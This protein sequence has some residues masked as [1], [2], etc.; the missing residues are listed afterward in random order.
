[1][2]AAFA[3]GAD[4]D[5]LGDAAD[6]VADCMQ[7]HFACVET[8]A[9]DTDSNYAVVKWVTWVSRKC[10]HFGKAYWNYYLAERMESFHS[11]SKLLFT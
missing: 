7:L 5:S 2:V 11:V 9:V 4:F 8:V 6:L 10:K 3:A 1:M